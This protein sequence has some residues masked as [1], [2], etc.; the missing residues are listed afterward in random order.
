MYYFFSIPQSSELQFSE[1][2]ILEK[3]IKE[4]CTLEKL[5][6]IMDLYKI[7]IE[8]YAALGDQRSQEYQSR[9]KNLLSLSSTRNALSSSSSMISKRKS[10][11][12]VMDLSTERV[13]HKEIKRH[14]SETQYATEIAQNDLKAQS[15]ALNVRVLQ[16]RKSNKNFSMFEKHVEKIIE[17]YVEEKEKLIS[18]GLETK[19]NIQNLEINKRIEI[20]KVRKQFLN[21]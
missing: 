7:A 17:K 12:F 6:E 15:D 18:A 16:R 14:N 5:K 2:A 13:V 11:E 20:A 19:Q 8:H 4:E 10:R 9:M 21:M 1:I 3:S